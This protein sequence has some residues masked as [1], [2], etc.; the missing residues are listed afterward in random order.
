MN[1]K[2]YLSLLKLT[3]LKKARDMASMGKIRQ[4]QQAR[5]SERK[6]LSKTAHS[7]FPS[8]NTHTDQDLVSYGKWTKWSDQ[9]QKTLQE[10]D[11][12][13]APVLETARKTL[14]RSFGEAEALTNLL[15]IAERREKERKAQRAERSGLPR[16]D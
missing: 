16:E 15:E 7:E 5:L 10:G 4:R 3:E 14:A 6:E 1:P 9:R 12:S 8:L 2:A 11:I 13:D